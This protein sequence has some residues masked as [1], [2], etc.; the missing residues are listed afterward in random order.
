[1]APGRLASLTLHQL[2]VFA[3][4]AREGSFGRAAEFL[5]ISVPSVSDQVRSLEHVVG[6]RLLERSPGRRGVRLT[7]AGELLLQ[8]YAQFEASFEDA[9]RQME[10]LEAGPEQPTITFGA[11]MS[12][13]GYAFPRMYEA[14]H[15]AYPDVAVHLEIGNRV[16]VLDG[17]RHGRLDLGVVLGPVEVPE[18]T[19]EL[20]DADVEVVL[21]GPLGHRLAA[22][23]TAPFSELSAEHIVTPG[24][25]SPIFQALMRLANQRK[26]RLHVA[27]RV[28]NIEAQ[29]QAI[30]SGVGIGA[31]VRDAVEQRV[32]AGQ[33]SL[34]N[35][36]GFPLRLQQ[37]LMHRPGQLT[38]AGDVFRTF[39]LDQC[40]SRRPVDASEDTS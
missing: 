12:F 22:N 20:L 23:R 28:G 17:L 25:M 29:T 33:L 37:C 32:A 6:A 16:E 2:H 24:E 35:V 31:T 39:L 40:A 7:T 27:W 34:L 15:R 13:G 38:A 4:V 21:V 18:L 19:I 26:T 8:S 1:M 10:A 36:E 30:A 14:F 3:A 11:S 9:L 5:T